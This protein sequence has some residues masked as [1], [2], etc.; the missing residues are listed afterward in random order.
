[1]N[2]MGVVYRCKIKQ[3]SYHKASKCPICDGDSEIAFHRT[4]LK[5]VFNPFFRLFGFHV[6]SVF[7]NN[8]FI[9]YS[10]AKTNFR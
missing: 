1:M 4:W 10:F 3:H 2:K 5:V 6:V 8:K 7:D 9:K